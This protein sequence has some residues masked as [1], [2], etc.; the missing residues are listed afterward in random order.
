M[1]QSQAEGGLRCPS[2]ALKKMN[3]AKEA[4]DDE[5]YKKAKHDYYVTERGIKELRESGREELADKLQ[6]RREQLIR[7]NQKD[8]RKKNN[9]T[10]AVDLDNTTADFTGS[11]RACLAKKYGMTKEEAMAKYPDPENYNMTSWFPGGSSEF[12]EEFTYAESNGVYENMEMFRNAR[13]EILGLH[14]DGYTLH[15]VTARN[16]KFNP[17]TKIALRRYR[18][19]Y[20]LLKHLEKKEEHPAHVFLDD[21]PKQIKTLS[22]NGKK[23]VTFD[24]A[25]NAE[26]HE[27]VDRIKGWA[28]ISDVVHR[29]TSE[30]PKSEAHF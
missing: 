4:G 29:H 12:M 26:N 9:I 21:A 1:C 22:M 7:R 27:G 23:V 28:G 11:F 20:H 24:N 25:Y 2:S 5:A 13:K 3:Q 10:V 14:N 30:N 8:W 19:P 17:N 15:F 18:L 16:E 6:K